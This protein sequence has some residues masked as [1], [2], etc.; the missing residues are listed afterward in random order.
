MLNPHHVD[1]FSSL[2]TE[3]FETLLSYLDLDS[4]K[5]LRLTSGSL[6]RRC[7]G[8]RFL[9]SIQQPVLDV[10]LENL[11]SLLALSRNHELSK[12][13]TTLTLL[14]TIMDISGLEQDIKNGW[15]RVVDFNGPIFADTAVDFSPEELA[16]A[17][18]DLICAVLRGPKQTRSLERGEWVS[19]WTRASKV[20]S[21]VTTALAKSQASV[22]TFDA[23]QSNR[24]C[25]LEASNIVHHEL[26]HGPKELELSCKGL[27]SL[28]MSISGEVQD[29]LDF[30]RKLEEEDEEDEDDDRIDEEDDQANTRKEPCT[31][32]ENQTEPPRQPSFF[33]RSAPGLRKLE[34]SFRRTGELDLKFKEKYDWIID[35]IACEAEFP[36]LEACTFTGFPAKGESILLFLERHP[37]LRSLRIHECHLS[38]GSWTPIFAYLEQSMPELQHLSFSNLFGKHM[39]NHKYAQAQELNE[40]FGREEREDDWQEA[41]DIVILRP[42]WD[43]NMIRRWTSYSTSVGSV[44]HTRSFNRK[45]LKKGLVF[46]PLNKGPRYSKSSPEQWGWRNQRKVL[47]GPPV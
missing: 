15:Y 8:P 32:Q 9:E 11:R 2:P 4:I 6:A 43:N 44:V 30:K 34:L 25:G 45:E 3:I 14:A 41:D 36:M 5:V 24:E 26:T 35:S 18:E 16:K 38:S 28:E 29:A 22:K 31:S 23:Y 10:S 7:I 1:G 40:D 19:L 21:W 13:I 46:R 12:K 17:K 37:S 20:F 47:Y 39:Q 33:L 27:Q 42:I